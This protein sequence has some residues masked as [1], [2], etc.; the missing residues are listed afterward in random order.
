MGPVYKARGDEEKNI[1]KYTH[2]QNAHRRNS[3]EGLLSLEE[4]KI[5]YA[6]NVD[7]TVLG[8]AAKAMRFFTSLLSLSSVRSIVVVG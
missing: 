1:Y 5:R 7:T 8:V 4:K 2:T 6:Y 3:G